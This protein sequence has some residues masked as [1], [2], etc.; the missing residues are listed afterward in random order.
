MRCVVLKVEL[1]TGMFMIWGA[2]CCESLRECRLS[3]WPDLGKAIVKRLGLCAF[4][5]VLSLL[6]KPAKQET[7]ID[8]GHHSHSLAL[9]RTVRHASKSVVGVACRRINSED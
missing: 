4:F 7:T 5:A 6:K 1:V 3:D 9:L 8:G 2:L